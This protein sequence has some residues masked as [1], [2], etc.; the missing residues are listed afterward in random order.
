M[1]DHVRPK[2]GRARDT[3]KARQSVQQG[4]RRSAASRCLE[5]S[6]VETNCWAGISSV[7]RKCKSFR[8]HVLRRARVQ[9][10]VFPR[11]MACAHVA[12]DQRAFPLEP[13]RIPPGAR[14]HVRW[15][16]RALARAV[17][18]DL[19]PQQATQSRFWG[20]RQGGWKSFQKGMGRSGPIAPERTAARLPTCSDSSRRF[21]RSSRRRFRPSPA[22]SAAALPSLATSPRQAAGSLP[23]PAQ[24]LR[25][26]PTLPPPP[27][28][29][30]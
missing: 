10:G 27:T 7:A 3:Q 1:L 29:P 17:N 18:W 24:A 20:A 22:K 5:T 25:H 6:Y 26:L 2:G 13:Q 16:P 23:R 14:A 9:E 30:S 12:C 19:T 11:D 4:R 8:P 15:G 28:K 21:G